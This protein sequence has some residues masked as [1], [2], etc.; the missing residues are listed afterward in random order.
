MASLEDARQRGAG[1]HLAAVLARSQ[2][3]RSWL[4]LCAL[5]TGSLLVRATDHL[6]AASTDEP[7]TSDRARLESLRALPLDELTA[8]S[9]R[10]VMAVCESPSIYRRLPQKTV[11]C[12][13][14]LYRFLIRNPE[15]IVNI[16]QLMGVSNM[17][18]QR[19]GPYAWQG[20][21]GTGTKCDVELVYGTEELHVMYSDGFYEG[22]LLKRKV[23][24]RCVLIL[25][26][27]Y[28]QNA[29]RRWLVGNRL[30]VFLQIDNAGADLIAR[31]LAP[32]V[33]KVADT[34]FA[35]SC[36]FAAK[37]SQTA[38]QNGPG[39]QRLADKLTKVEP[40]IREQ[41]ARVSVGVQQRAA[42]RDAGEAR[43][44]R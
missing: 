25:Q 44:R 29:A 33:G 8:E 4:S 43:P 9:R 32:W 41:F 26:S 35:E 30:D 23:T 13:P 14:D 31:T 10:K 39:M 3:R 20:D 21:D 38:E 17:T 34:N 36:K 6:L 2:H 12:D 7:D 24:G 5:A 22:S 40:R 37:V 11:D 42:L 18:A 1:V 16:W 19:T 27:G 15:V 28:G